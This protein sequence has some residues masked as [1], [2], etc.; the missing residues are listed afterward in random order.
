MRKFKKDLDLK[1][2]EKFGFVKHWEKYGTWIIVDGHHIVLEAY[3][4]PFVKH[5][6]ICGTG[7]AS[8]TDLND[9]VIQALTE[10]GL[11]EKEV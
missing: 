10:S 6:V 3:Y 9:K 11:I 4:Y 8:K 5:N 2:L 1:E 7:I